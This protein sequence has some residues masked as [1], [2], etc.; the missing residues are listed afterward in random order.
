MGTR[1]TTLTYH[2]GG[3]VSSQ[4]NEIGIVETDRSGLEKAYN[5]KVYK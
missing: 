2:L 3:F 5:K 4:E 1:G